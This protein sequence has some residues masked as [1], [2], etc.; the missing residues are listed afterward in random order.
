MIRKEAP[1]PE[2]EHEAQH[3]THSG[4]AEAVVPAQLL[5]QR[6]A[7][8]RREERAQVDAHVED[9]EGAVAARVAG[10]VLST[11]CFAPDPPGP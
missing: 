5:A 6:A 3:H 11:Y 9:R 2:I 8:Q 1:A 7:D 10:R 4:G